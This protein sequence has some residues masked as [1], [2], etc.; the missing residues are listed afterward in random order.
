LILSKKTHFYPLICVALAFVG[1][2]ES[3]IFEETKDLKTEFWR[4]NDSLSYIVDIQDTAKRYDIIAAIAHNDDYTNEN[5]YV[6]IRTKFPD[7]KTQQD[8]ISLELANSKGEWY[9]EGSSTVKLDI[10]LQ[11]KARL[12]QKGKYTFSF[13]QYTRTDSLQGVKGLGLKLKTH[14]D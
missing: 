11:T 14:T 13:K 5:L 2:G 4:Y 7:G 10:P 9:G 6:K 12:T 1:C 8:I 3:Y